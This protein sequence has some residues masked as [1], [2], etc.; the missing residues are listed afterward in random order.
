MLALALL[1]TGPL[2]VTGFAKPAG[3]RHQRR[4]PRATARCARN[5]GVDL[6]KVAIDVAA[7]ATLVACN[8]AVDSA[9]MVVMGIHPEWF[10]ATA[11]AAPVQVVRFV[12]PGLHFVAAA[13]AWSAAAAATGA[14]DVD[15]GDT[16]DVVVKCARTWAACAVG[17]VLLWAATHDGALLPLAELTFVGGVGAAVVTLRVAL[18]LAR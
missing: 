4:C 12:S 16:R 17:A 8:T 3:L 15:V 2:F 7:I 18:A 5:D 14:S 13:S 6:P 10:S 9:S 1:A 11:G